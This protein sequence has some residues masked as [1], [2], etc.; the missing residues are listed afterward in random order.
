LKKTAQAALH[1][2]LL[3]LNNTICVILMNTYI[4]H[5]FL[6]Y[7]QTNNTKSAKKKRKYR[8]KGE[9]NGKRRNCKG[10]PAYIRPCE[11][12]QKKDR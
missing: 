4:L 5:P 10:T 1:R 7:L 11:I 3:K 8:M 9:E 2:F 12:Q 6:L